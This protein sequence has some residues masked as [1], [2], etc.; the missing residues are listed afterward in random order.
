MGTEGIWRESREIP[1]LEFWKIKIEIKDRTINKKKIYIYIY[2]QITNPN[3]EP[4]SRIIV[5]G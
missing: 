4:D 5:I 3:D 2:I 1:T